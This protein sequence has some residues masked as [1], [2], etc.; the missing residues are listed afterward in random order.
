MVQGA[1]AAGIGSIAMAVTSSNVLARGEAGDQE[2]VEL[3]ERSP[4]TFCSR[5]YFVGQRVQ[6][7]RRCES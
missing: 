4:P 1:S 6:R 5:R 7:R 2:F 3:E